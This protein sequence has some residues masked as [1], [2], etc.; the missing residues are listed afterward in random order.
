MT[1]WGKTKT[2]ER[3]KRDNLNIAITRIDVNGWYA[4]FLAETIIL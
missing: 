4:R 2:S 3:W 1:S